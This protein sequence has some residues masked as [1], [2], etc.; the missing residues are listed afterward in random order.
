MDNDNAVFEMFVRGQPESSTPGVG[1][2][3][4]IC[5]AIV[6]AHSGSITT[7]N[8]TQGG[9]CVTFYLPLGDPPRIEDEVLAL[10]DGRQPCNP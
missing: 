3:L 4:A 1:L 7:A 9:A 10:E 5:R 2:G 8:R 6:E